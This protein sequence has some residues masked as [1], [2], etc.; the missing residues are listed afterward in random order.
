M[1]QSVK[2]RAPISTEQAASEVATP[3]KRKWWGT[4]EVDAMLFKIALEFR[5]VEE[6][7]YYLNGVFIEKHPKSGVLLI[8]TDGH[9]MIVIH[10]ESGRCDQSMI[11]N[12]PRN[13]FVDVKVPK[14][15]PEARARLVVDSEGRVNVGAY[16]S[17]ECSVIDGTYPDYQLVL[18]PVVEALKKGDVGRSSLK[19]PYVA[20]FARAAESLTDKGRAIRM[21]STAEADPVLILFDGA[22]H[23]LGILMPMRATTQNGMP[24][25]MQ[26]V[27]EPRAAKIAADKLKR[28]KEAQKEE[29]ARLKAEARAQ[30]LAEL[31]AHPFR[32]NEGEARKEVAPSK[33]PQIT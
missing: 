24:A 12:V 14:R 11:V 1:D 3:P 18:L 25:F 20:S 23:A 2:E 6:T 30:R 33:D 29:A 7:R 26:P 15:A 10:D 5:S 31:K 19:A 9:R 27:L 4:A 22:V 21:I 16:R 28:E 32:C 17:I 8:A 13:A